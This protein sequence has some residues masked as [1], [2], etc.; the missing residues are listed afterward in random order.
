MNLA[1]L[2]A[3]L[4]E[5]G[6]R[7]RFDEDGDLLFKSEGRYLYI[8]DYADD[9]HF[10]RL[11]AP[12]LWA[13][14]SEAERQQ[15]MVL[16]NQVTRAFKSAKVFLIENQANVWA[17]IELFIADAAA[18]TAVL[19]RCL[20]TLESAIHLFHEGMHTGIAALGT[21]ALPAP[22]PEPTLLSRWFERLGRGGDLDQ[23]TLDAYLTVL[24]AYGQGEAVATARGYLEQTKAAARL[25]QALTD[26]AVLALALPPRSTLP[27]LEAAYRHLWERAQATRDIAMMAMVRLS[28]MNRLGQERQRELIGAWP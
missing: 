24:G 26:A 7:P 2:H 10:I 23:A 16:A 19:P 20:S 21:A 12:N 3:H 5:E 25:A 4:T 11:F 9:E 15:A 22:T 8:D 28:M 18:F 13:I 1:K 27:A 6:Y 17:S 14:E